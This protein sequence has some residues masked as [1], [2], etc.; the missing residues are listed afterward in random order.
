MEKVLLST[1]TIELELES[2]LLEEFD[3]AESSAGTCKVSG[4][5]LGSSSIAVVSSAEEDIIMNCG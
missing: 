5:R 1:V 4:F 2:R 3:R